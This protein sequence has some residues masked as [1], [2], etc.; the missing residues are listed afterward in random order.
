MSAL[1]REV[2]AAVRLTVCWTDY[3]LIAVDVKADRV[4]TGLV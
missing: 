3:N 4:I 1:R 2:R